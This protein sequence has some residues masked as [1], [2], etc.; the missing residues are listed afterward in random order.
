MPAKT[1][2]QRRF[3]GAELSRARAGEKTRTGM[4][5]EKLSEF[6][7][8][9]IDA[10]LYKHAKILPCGHR[11]EEGS[12]IDKACTSGGCG[13]MGGTSITPYRESGTNTGRSG[14]TY[15]PSTDNVP[16]GIHL[17]SSGSSGPSAASFATYG[18]KEGGFNRSADPVDLI[19]RYLNKQSRHKCGHKKGDP[20]H[21]EAA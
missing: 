3:M 7:S 20:D 16:S 13:A 9:S 11:V 5:E 18:P 4:S 21:L 1:E 19:N 12:D 8:K 10:Y 6:A 15:A 2:K 17:P 14:T